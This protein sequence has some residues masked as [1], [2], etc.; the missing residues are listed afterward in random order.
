MREDPRRLV[1]AVAQL[2]LVGAVALPNQGAPTAMV[3]ALQVATLAAG[4]LLWV[5][6]RLSG[7]PHLLGLV[8]IFV[9]PMLSLRFET[10]GEFGASV[11]AAVS[12]LMYAAV[13]SSLT[14]EGFKRLC[15]TTIFLA[16]IES[17]LAGYQLLTQTLPTWGVLGDPM[18]VLV[19]YNELLGEV[20]GGRASGT[21]SHP[22]PLGFLCAVGLTFAFSRVLKIGLPI[23]VLTV[24]VLLSGLAASGTRSA[25]LAACV[26]VVGALLLRPRPDQLE[27]SDSTRTRANTGRLLAAL[28][29]GGAAA[30]GAALSFGF[31]SSL[32]GS[33]SSTHRINTIVGGLNLFN[34]P[35]WEVFFGSGPSGAQL[36]YQEGFIPIDGSF[37]LD[38]QFVWSFA[39]GGL[40]QVAAISIVLVSRILRAVPPVSDL[41]IVVGVMCFSFDILAWNAPAILFVVIAASN[42]YRSSADQVVRRSLPRGASG[43]KA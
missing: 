40:V 41:M 33:F 24:A 35:L 20:V 17:L 13:V 15:Q 43:V 25:V 12:T 36:A 37:A 10:F 22:I 4:V 6:R 39:V 42:F 34:R 23:R 31:A 14:T 38:N 27:V 32:Q 8:V 26:G 7:P 30:L 21:M 19:G 1:T 2:G 11:L 5:G 28:V 29:L 18:R 3:A 16:A 9:S